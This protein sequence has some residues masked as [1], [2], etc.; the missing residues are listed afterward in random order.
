MGTS[1]PSG[2]ALLVTDRLGRGGGGPGVPAAGACAISIAQDDITAIPESTTRCVIFIRIVSSDEIYFG[3][4]L[5]SFRCPSAHRPRL[6]AGVVDWATS[7][8]GIA[9]ARTKQEFITGFLMSLSL[10]W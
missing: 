2:H 6:P 9:A 10:C 1:P 3:V 5:S 8:M 7:A 4:S